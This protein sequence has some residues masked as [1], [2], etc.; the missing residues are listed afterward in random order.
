MPPPIGCLFLLV[1]LTWC[2]H[3]GAQKIPSL[4]VVVEELSNAAEACGINGASIESAVARTLRRNGI[5]VLANLASPYSYLYVSARMDLVPVAGD[6]PLSCIVE[7]HVEVVDVSPTRAPVGGFKG[8]SS[9]RGTT[10][11]ILCSSIATSR[12]SP[13]N[14]E[15]T[16]NRE[17]EQRI[18]LCLNSLT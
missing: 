18:M 17:L 1:L 16:F 14:L 4:H 7:T 15:T 6:F 5:Q 13:P 3:A 11:V 2:G 12:G 8:P 9:K 10:E